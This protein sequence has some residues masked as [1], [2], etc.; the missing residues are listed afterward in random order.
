MITVLNESNPKAKKD[1][2]CDASEFIL[3]NG[4]P[5]YFKSINEYRDYINAKNNR[6]K[7]KKGEIYLKQVNV[8][9]GDFYVFRS[10]PSMHRIC[11]KYDLYP[12]V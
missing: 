9:D 2:E 10:I 5:D 1:Y 11:I 12:E 3:E 7:I 4:K 8:Q 6:F